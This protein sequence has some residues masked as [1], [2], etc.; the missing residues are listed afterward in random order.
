VAFDHPL[1][2]LGEGLQ[3]F[4]AVEGEPR[5]RHVRIA[6]GCR[7][8]QVEHAFLQRRQRVNVLQVGGAAGHLGDQPLD[9]RLIQRH[10]RQHV[11]GDA[12]R[13]AQPVAT[14]TGDQFQQLRLVF[15]EAVPQRIVQR[16]VAAQNDQVFIFL[17][18]ADR[19]G[20][21]NSHQFAEMHGITC[22]KYEKKERAAA[23][24]CLLRAAWKS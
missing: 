3:P 19:M 6:G 13:R 16:V 24:P 20:G 7:Q 21:K 22:C 2:R 10:Q 15:A 8:V 23:S 4:A 11:R 17:L 1:Q 14:M 12:K 18:K 9:G 5:L